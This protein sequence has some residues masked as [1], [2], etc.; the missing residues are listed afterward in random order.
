M[1]RVCEVGVGV[2]IWPGWRLE[3]NGR[4]DAWVEVAI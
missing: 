1:D 2:R 3:G 4:S